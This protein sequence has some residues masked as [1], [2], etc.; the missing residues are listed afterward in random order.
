VTDD[1]FGRRSIVDES[2][3]RRGNG[4]AELSRI[5]LEQP[6]RQFGNLS[7]PAHAMLK[8]RCLI[9]LPLQMEA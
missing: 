3:R 8:K 5:T 2:A 7:A 4:N 9:F 1:F 6:R